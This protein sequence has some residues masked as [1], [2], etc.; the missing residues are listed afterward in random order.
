MHLPSATNG[1]SPRPACPCHRRAR[2]C[3]RRN[4]ALPAPA[5]PC[6][7]T[8]LPHCSRMPR[9]LR[10]IQPA[11]RSEP[12]GYSLHTAS[13]V[14]QTHM[15]SSTRISRRPIGPKQPRTN[16]SSLCGK[17]PHKPHL[18]RAPHRK[19]P[20]QRSQ[21]L[22]LPRTLSGIIWPSRNPYCTPIPHPDP[23]ALFP[24]RDR[25]TPSS[26]S[27]FQAIAYNQQHIQ[28]IF[29]PGREGSSPHRAESHLPHLI[30]QTRRVGVGQSRDPREGWHEW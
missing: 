22:T 7:R 21:T 16:A 12:P 23:K 25:I 18:P 8:P 24:D 14:H 13:N 15:R 29:V 19:T 5:R 20:P 1:P 11:A 2:A 3:C 6:K 4:Q 10:T 30:L 26:A 9:L 27:H 28:Q 17:H